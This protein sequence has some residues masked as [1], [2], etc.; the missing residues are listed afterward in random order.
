MHKIESSFS[1]LQGIRQSFPDKKEFHELS[2]VPKF[3]KRIIFSL[4]FI[5]VV[6]S[7]IELE[8]DGDV[9]ELYRDVIDNS[10]SFSTFSERFWRQGLSLVWRK[11]SRT[12]ES[13]E[14]VSLD[15]RNDPSPVFFPYEGDKEKKRGEKRPQPKSSAT[16]WCERWEKISCEIFVFH[17]HTY[18]TLV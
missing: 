10:S 8:Q 16:E 12:R 17:I 1:F 2:S 14:K 5:F 13:V 15:E 7:F 3:W 6:L 4:V 9:S 18:E 11:P